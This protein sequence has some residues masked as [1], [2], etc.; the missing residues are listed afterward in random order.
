MLFEG[1]YIF[2][3]LAECWFW[4][5]MFFIHF[6]VDFSLQ[7]W[8]ISAIIAVVWPSLG[9]FNEVTNVMFENTP[10]YNTC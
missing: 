2:F 3:L 1:Q 9:I 7:D 10:K 5:K 6:F 4:L 8:P